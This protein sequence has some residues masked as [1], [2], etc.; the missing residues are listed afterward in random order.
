ML[1]FPNR[2]NICRLPAT[3]GNGF[4]RRERQQGGVV[5]AKALMLGDESVP[6][7]SGIAHVMV[8][9]ERTGENTT[10]FLER[11]PAEYPETKGLLYLP[12]PN[13]KDPDA[14]FNVSLEASDHYGRYCQPYCLN[15]TTEKFQVCEPKLVLRSQLGGA[16]GAPASNISFTHQLSARKFLDMDLSVHP[17]RWKLESPFLVFSCQRKLLNSAL[18]KDVTAQL[19]PPALSAAGQK[20]AEEISAQPQPHVWFRVGLLKRAG[21]G[22]DLDQLQIETE[23]VQNPNEVFVSSVPR[24]RSSFDQSVL[25]V[26]ARNPLLLPAMAVTVRVS[27]RQAGMRIGCEVRCNLA[28]EASQEPAEE[29][30]SR[31]RLHADP[32]LSQEQVFSPEVA[33]LPFLGWRM[34]GH[35]SEWRLRMPY[36]ALYC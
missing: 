10:A 30:Q 17:S 3:E 22:R 36:L 15:S 23:D 5:W 2:Q 9:D 18:A 27:V 13:P 12:L 35:P 24:A 19:L 16:V 32:R 25:F 1:S 4:P 21:S 11:G 31:V 7:A 20:P 14:D 33:Y 34:V 28:D 26:R 29:C 8:R 6:L